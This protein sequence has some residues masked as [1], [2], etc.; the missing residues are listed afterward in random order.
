MKRVITFS[1]LT[2]LGLGFGLY[3]GGA[4]PRPTATVLLSR[5]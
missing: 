2:V 5:H 1:V 4:E 3:V